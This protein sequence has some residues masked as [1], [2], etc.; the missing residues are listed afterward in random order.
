MLTP[1]V[2]GGL[3]VCGCSLLLRETTFLDGADAGAM[4]ASVDAEVV[5]DAAGSGDAD[6][7]DGA[8]RLD[9]GE[10]LHAPLA[11]FPWNGYATGS[12]VALRPRLVWDAVAEA[13]HYQVQMDDSCEVREFRAC[14][15]ETPEI[16]EMVTA[17]SFTPRAPLTVSGLPPVGRRYTWRVRACRA[18]GE[19][20]DWT[21]PRYL[22]V[23]QSDDDF[24]G[25]GRGDVLIGTRLSRVFAYH[26]PLESEP[27]PQTTLAFP[28]PATGR[29]GYAS[30]AKAG[31]VNGDGYADALIGIPDTSNPE[32]REGNAYLYLGGPDGLSDTPSVTFDNPL[33][34]VNG[35]FGGTVR[36]VGDFDGD[37]YGDVAIAASGQD[38]VYVYLG[39]PAGPAATSSFTLAGA[40][41]SGFGQTLG[42]P[43]DTDGD[44]YVDLLVT[45]FVDLG[46]GGTVDDVGRVHV[47]SGGTSP[48]ELATRVLTSPEMPPARLGGSLM[49]RAADFDR[50]GFADAVVGTS[51]APGPSGSHEGRVFVFPG[52]RSG[53]G[54]RAPI[55]LH[56]PISQAWG[57]FFVT[58]VGDLDADGHSDLVVG[59]P[60]QNGDGGTTQRVG[61]AFRYLGSP[62]GL[63]A[64]M[65]VVQTP[66][67]ENGSFGSVIS[68]VDIDGSGSAH[69]L[70]AAPGVERG[71][72]YG[73]PSGDPTSPPRFVLTSPI[74]DDA[75][76]FGTSME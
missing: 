72:V 60:L 61:N 45:E 32:L 63:S 9:G 33:N 38:A 44:G 39:G 47:F 27:A 37:G 53:L 22:R 28:G 31:D 34:R 55:V 12:L 42:A 36:G 20:S 57:F 62:A 64:A 10:G 14:G 13:D 19:C 67:S 17:P 40:A 69:A 51:V 52:S 74:A 35:W 18:G 4:D 21:E 65:R 59:A 11:R 1:A 30:V 70:I 3:L 73:Y 24:D 41:A 50:D 29:S 46:G 7:P 56:S 68:V 66:T 16:D 8:A 48:S 58:G 6:V 26:G 5:E 25:D 15:F 71:G 75:A 2:I 49:V 43:G 23:G 76:S 54:D